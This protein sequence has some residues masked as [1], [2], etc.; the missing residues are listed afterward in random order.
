MF[1]DADLIQSYTRAEALADGVLVDV[2][3]TAREAGFRVPV[4]L[5]SAVWNDCVA[6][7]KEDSARVVYQDQAGRLWDVLWM[8]LVAARR[9]PEA[10][11]LTYDMLRVRRDG[12]KPA[13]TKVRLVLDIGPGDHGEA[14]ITIG[15]AEDF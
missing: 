5:T 9:Q 13:P 12:T 8:A 11:R 3:E 7:T 15:F 2:T 10:S 14:V 4:A 1:E 6:W